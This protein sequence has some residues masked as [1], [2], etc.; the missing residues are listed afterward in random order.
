MNANLDLLSEVE[1]ASIAVDATVVTTVRCEA[2]RRLSN[3]AVLSLIARDDSADESVRREATTRIHLCL[4]ATMAKC[5]WEAAV[6]AAARVRVVP[7]FR[8]TP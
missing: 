2:T 8:G 6:R 7:G 4:L 5:H 3:P 1:L